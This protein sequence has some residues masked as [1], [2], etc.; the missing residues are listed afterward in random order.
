L[1]K[2]EFDP[3]AA[4]PVASMLARVSTGRLVILLPLILALLF[5]ATLL[6]HTTGG[7]RDVQPLADLRLALNS[8]GGQSAPRFPLTRDFLTLWL[9]VAEV[10]TVLIVHR[11]WILMAE[12][13]GS[14][15]SSG[16]IVALNRPVP[17][18]WLRLGERL[19]PVEE[20]SQDLD[21]LE[22]VMRHAR[23]SLAVMRAKRGWVLAGLA[24]VGSAVVILG[25]NPQILSAVAPP[26]LDAKRDSAWL[27]NAYSSWWAGLSHPVGA[28]VYFLLIAF[29]IYLVLIQ[30]AIGL[31][32]SYFVL[33]LT[34]VAKLE[35]DWL[36]R[37]G[38]YGWRPIALIFRTVYW[39]LLLHGV[40]LALVVIVLGPSHVLLIMPLLA[41]WLLVAPIYIG[42][43]ILVFRRV[44]RSARAQ[45]LALIEG[46]MQCASISASSPAP[47]LAPYLLELDLA[48]N[49][50]IRPLSLGRLRESVI[51]TAFILPL[52]L[53]AIQLAASG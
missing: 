21:G 12:C 42:G 11:Q 8:G 22:T 27:H 18:R 38:H 23:S 39:S 41:V 34:K 49:A 31:C 40:T 17:S 1:T 30:N 32:C 24:L 16:A 20:G 37:D 15:E 28:L 26:G 3:F 9:M 44:E 47:A 46:Q 43:S 7:L 52:I 4:S 6:E 45:R 19:F 50:R 51:F 14:L 2:R 33:T 13:V 53:A 29:G 36:N 25:E 5:A 48:I 35:A 10:A